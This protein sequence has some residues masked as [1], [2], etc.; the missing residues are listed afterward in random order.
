MGLS[1]FQILNYKVID[2]TRQVPAERA[3]TA[4]VGRNERDKT[5]ILR[6]MWKSRNVTAEPCDKL[7]DHLRARYASERRQ[8][9]YVSFLEFELEKEGPQQPADKLALQ[10]GRTAGIVILRT[11]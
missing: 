4:L 5:A 3:V 11:W 8:S 10:D 7:L 6:A 9:Q 2:D 1:T